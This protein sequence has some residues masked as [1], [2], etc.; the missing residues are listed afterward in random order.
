MAEAANP[1]DMR[2]VDARLAHVHPDAVVSSLAVV[3][4][5]GEWRN[6]PSLFPVIVGRGATIRELCTVHAGCDRDTIIGPRTLLMAR[7][8]VGHDVQIG[9]GC[10]LAPGATIGGCVTIGDGVKIGMN[11]CVKPF[12]K[13]GSGA[14]IGMGAVVTKDVGAN[15][16]W[17]GNPARQ[18]HE[19]K[20]GS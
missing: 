12:V 15:Q 19:W 10:E 20:K 8:H 7:V 3:G 4:A 11:A 2:C 17:F 1:P 13:I 16:T 6:R 14:R 18:K 9:E 5:P